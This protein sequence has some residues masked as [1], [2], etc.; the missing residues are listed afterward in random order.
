[1]AKTLPPGTVELP[2]GTTF[3]ANAVPDVFDGRDLEYRPR[4]VPL[5]A[6]VDPRP[7]GRHRVLLQEGNSCTGHAVAAMVNTVLVVIPAAA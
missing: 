5:P 1:M 2:E 3:V 7:D 6:S 4:L